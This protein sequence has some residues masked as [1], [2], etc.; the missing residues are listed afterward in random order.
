MALHWARQMDFSP[1]HPDVWA[2]TYQDRWNYY[3]QIREAFEESY[4]DTIDELQR[5][6]GDPNKAASGM[7]NLLAKYAG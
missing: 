1:M 4:R 3:I 5:R 6:K 2:E 7:K